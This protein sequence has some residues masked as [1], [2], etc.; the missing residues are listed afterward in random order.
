M[1]CSRLRLIPDQPARLA[2]FRFAQDAFIRFEMASRSAAVHGFRRVFV[3]VWVCL[4]VLGVGLLAFLRFAHDAFIRAETAFRAAALIGLRPVFVFGVDAVPRAV[5][6]PRR[7]LAAVCR[8]SISLPSC[9]IW[10]CLAAM[11]S[12]I[13]LLTVAGNVM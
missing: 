11:A 4:E 2:R 7:A 9:V 12:V 6:C 8:A 5:F 13:W 10:A 1:L 3:L